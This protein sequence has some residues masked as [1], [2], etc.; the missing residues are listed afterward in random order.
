MFMGEYN[1]T[2]DGKGRV[3]IPSRFR[4]KLGDR[5]VITKSFDG[6]LSIYDEE[7]WEALQA[8]LSKMPMLTEESRMLRRMMVGSAAE[9]ETDRQG[10]VL[11]PAPLRSYAHIEKDVVLI[12]NIDHIEIW[13]GEDWEKAQNFDANQAAEK[14]YGSGITL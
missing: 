13:S 4:E 9:C 8:T 12:G 7:N 11:I 1:H 5:F 10:R 3:I 2:L 6:C 14:L